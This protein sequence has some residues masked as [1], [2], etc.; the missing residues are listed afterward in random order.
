MK[1]RIATITK[2]CQSGKKVART[3]LTAAETAAP[4]DHEPWNEPSSTLPSFF[5]NITAWE[6]RA[7]LKVLNAS[8]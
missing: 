7:M 6:L 5:W 8:D 3:P 1:T 4:I 2:C